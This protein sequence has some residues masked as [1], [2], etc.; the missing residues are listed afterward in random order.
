[1]AVRSG[2]GSQLA[3]FCRYDKVPAD[4]REDVLWLASCIEPHL[5]GIKERL[6]ELPQ[7]AGEVLDKV[8]DGVDQASQVGPWSTSQLLANATPL[9]LGI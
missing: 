8:E 5:A 4:L 7:Q 9:Q 3:L 2:E 6:H 1:M